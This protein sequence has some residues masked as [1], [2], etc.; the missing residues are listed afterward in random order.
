MN[1]VDEVLEH[2]EV[3]QAFQN[4]PDVPIAGASAMS[5]PDVLFLSD[6]ITLHAVDMY[7]KYSLLLP[8]HSEDPQEV[9]DVF[10][11]G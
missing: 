5:T 1:Y 3:R 11:G 6:I 2:C 8:E 10:C 7:S 9:W 4:A